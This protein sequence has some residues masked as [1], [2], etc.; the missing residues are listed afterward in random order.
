MMCKYPKISC[1]VLNLVLGITWMDVDYLLNVR[2]EPVYEPRTYEKYLMIGKHEKSLYNIRMVLQSSGA[3]SLNDV[4]T[5][6]GGSNPISMDEYYGAATG[7]PGSGQISMNVFYGKSKAPTGPPSPAQTNLSTLGVSGGLGSTSYEIIAGLY[8]KNLTRTTGRYIL[9]DGSTSDF[10]NQATAVGG[11]NNVSTPAAIIQARSGDTIQMIARAIT[12]GSYSEHFEFWY[13]GASGW[14]RAGSLNYTWSGSRDATYNLVL[15][16][17][18][19]GNYALAV[20]LS[21]STVGSTSYRS[22]KS[23]SLHIW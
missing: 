20:A 7:I 21:Y 5:E 6:F 13:Y 1:E 17:L 3:I 23:Y 8:A 10:R 14:V 12:R 15:P 22:W 9:S 19:A 11:S 16:T 18:S 4:Q 2:Q